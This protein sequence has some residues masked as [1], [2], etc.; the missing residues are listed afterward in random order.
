MYFQYL[1]CH[2]RKL[3]AAKECLYLALGPRKKYHKA[4]IDFSART[5]CGTQSENRLEH[6]VLT[7]GGGGTS[8]PGHYNASPPQNILHSFQT[9]YA[10]MATISTVVYRLGFSSRVDQNP[11]FSYPTGRGAKQLKE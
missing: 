10:I 11:S 7:M 9:K 6:C 5:S 1:H 3:L 2:L 4:E 8:D